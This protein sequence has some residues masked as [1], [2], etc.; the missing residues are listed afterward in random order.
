MTK[1]TTPPN[2]LKK[3]LGFPSLF[4]IAAGLVVSQGSYVSILQ[5][6]GYGAGSFFVAILIAYVLTL[7]YI[8]TYAELSLM[9]PKAGSISTY[10]TVSMGDFVAIIAAVSGYLAAIVFLGPAELLLL[11]HVLNAI[12]PGVFPNLAIATVWFFAVLNL[13]GID[14]FA[15]V[16]SVITYTML[17][18]L[19]LLGFAGL[20]PSGAKGATITQVWHGF[21]HPGTSVF[22]LV[23]MALLALMSFELLCPLIEE[24]KE[25]EKNI[26]KAMFIASIVMFTAYGL[27][28]FAGLH[29]LSVSQL[30][31]SDIPHLELGQAILGNA[32]KIVIAVLAITTTTGLMN[33][34]LAAVARMLYGM[35]H[36]KQLPSIFMKLHPRWKTPWFGILFLAVLITIPLLIVG[37]SPDFFLPLLLSGSTCWLVAYIIAH[38]NVIILRKR[39]PGHK[40]VFRTPFYPLPQ[41]IG[42]VGMSY[43]IYNNAPTAAMRWKVYVISIFFFAVTGLYAFIWLKYKKRKD[44]F[45]PRPIQEVMAE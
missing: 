37:N 43:A 19:F 33:A 5:G 2:G 4:I 31:N 36:Q 27:L 45:S 13:L 12:A 38:I 18:T 3:I 14:L 22:S 40:R 1:K 30:T 35:A 44:L 41:I 6:V 7:C 20:S 9:M 25:P 42:I 8:S 32:G 26:P 34:N 23:T 28:A 11:Q 16:Q 21:V 39:Y 29:Q 10:T 15:S 17:I 24:S